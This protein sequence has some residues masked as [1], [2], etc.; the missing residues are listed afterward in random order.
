M[1]TDLLKE[2]A[3]LGLKEEYGFAPEIES[4]EIVK[5]QEFGFTF[6]VGKHEYTYN[7]QSD[8]R[9]TIRKLDGN[10]K[11]YENQAKMYFDKWL[12]LLL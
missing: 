11:F 1:K 3:K 10:E 12:E 8:I 9:S 2:S 5:I 7:Y 6:K 4:I